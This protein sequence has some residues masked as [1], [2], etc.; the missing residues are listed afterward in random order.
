MAEH[1]V[2]RREGGD[3]QGV[4]HQVV[5][6][7]PDQHRVN[8]EAQHGS[9]RTLDVVAPAG[10]PERSVPVAPCPV[11]V[12]QEVRLDRQDQLGDIGQDG[13]NMGNPHKEYLH[14]EPGGEHGESDQAE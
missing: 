4:G 3:E 9:R 6:A 10:A 7:E 14:A 11:I 8:A 5:H 1:V 12:G 13:R 2:R